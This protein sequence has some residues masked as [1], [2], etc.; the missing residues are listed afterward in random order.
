MAIGEV[1]RTSPSGP[2]TQTPP[3]PPHP[4]VHQLSPTFPHQPL[5][6][7]PPP[8]A[9]AALSDGPTLILMRGTFAITVYV[10][11]YNP[12]SSSPSATSTAAQPIDSTEPADAAT[13]ITSQCL[14][15]LLATMPVKRV[16][17]KH[18][19]IPYI[20]S[21]CIDVP[22]YFL[23]SRILTQI[24]F[25]RRCRSGTPD[26][27]ICVYW[28]WGSKSAVLWYLCLTENMA[29]FKGCDRPERLMKQKLILG[30]TP[31]VLCILTLHDPMRAFYGSPSE[32]CSVGNDVKPAPANTYCSL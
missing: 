30:P 6:S 11:I 24:A 32:E 14:L 7:S 2:L 31:T 13:C 23:C 5:W 20:K 22:L 18:N 17:P 4:Y 26:E 19:G 28:W 21:G 12:M 8:L 10:V 1:R 25:C 3:P 9:P 15:M 29:L 27:V 16:K